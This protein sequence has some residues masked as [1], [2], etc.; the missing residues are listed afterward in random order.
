MKILHN[1][2][3]LSEYLYIVKRED[4]YRHK[5][6]RKKL[7][8]ELRESGIYDEC[9]LDAIM[10]V[11]RH[12]F[13]DST[14]EQYAYTNCKRGDKVLEIG[15]GSGFQCAV[16]CSMGFK[17]HS[18]ERQKELFDT[19]G[20]LLRSI[21]YKPNLYY[22]DGYKGKDVFAPFD[23]IIVTCGAPEVPRA[24]LSQLAI[25]AR[26]VIPVGSG[27]KQRMLTID[28]IGK[29]EYNQKDHGNA[30][31]VPMLESRARD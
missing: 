24:L 22:G 19:A 2:F 26:L 27:D 17:V 20:P 8:N 30:A 23:G 18:I 3:N 21:G 13:I 31:F 28:R 12:F 11:P 7:V 1:L 15:T 10:N 4:L 5:G 14:F 29:K 6:M 25:G 9:V 16:L